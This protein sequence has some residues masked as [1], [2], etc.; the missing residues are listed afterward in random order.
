MKKAPVDAPRFDTSW[1]VV[2]HT[3]TCVPGTFIGARRQIVCVG[4]AEIWILPCMVRVY[5]GMLAD[6]HFKSR[7]WDLWCLGSRT[8]F[9]VSPRFLLREPF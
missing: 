3:W 1:P 9:S 7:L 2:L 6:R 4:L 8:L 5:A